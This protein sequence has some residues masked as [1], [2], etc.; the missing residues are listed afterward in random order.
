MNIPPIRAAAKIQADIERVWKTLFNENGWDDWFTNGMRVQLFEG[1]KIFFRWLIE[2]EEVI[3]QGINLA[4]IPPKLWEFEWNEY[5][6]GYRSKTTIHLHEAHDGGTWVEIEDRV[7]I[8]KEKDLEIAF[9]CA[10][11]WGEFITRLK[12]W[13]ERGIKI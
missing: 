7:L 1:G 5:E 4:I 11:G 13:I 2:G 12:L 10:V 9:N 3:D 8:L 6:D